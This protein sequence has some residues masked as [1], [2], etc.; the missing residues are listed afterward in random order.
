MPLYCSQRKPVAR[1]DRYTI[2]GRF[3]MPDLAVIPPCLVGAHAL[4]P[5]NST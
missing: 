1:T 5:F 2:Y 4:I 3:E